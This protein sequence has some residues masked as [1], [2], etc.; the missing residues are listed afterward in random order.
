M[1]SPMPKHRRTNADG[2]SAPD[3]YMAL[4]YTMVHSDAWRALSGGALKVLIELY[5]RYNGRNN[6]A[7]C[8]SYADAS[9][10]L[11]LG[12]A[13]IKRA[14]D[15]L[16]SKGFIQLVKQGHW[17]GRKAAE[18]A[19]TNKPLY[20]NMASNDWKHWRVKKTVVASNMEGLSP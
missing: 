5:S 4:P 12:H 14:F 18:W 10:K 6:G 15:E 19:I 9:K 7:L 16:R 1:V 2:R 8:L 11:A 13:T 20:G 3:Q 17:Y